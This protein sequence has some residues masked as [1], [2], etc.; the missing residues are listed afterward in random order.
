MSLR[1]R[2]TKAKKRVIDKQFER[3]MIEAD[4]R[5]KKRQAEKITILL[6]EAEA[7]HKS[8]KGIV[9][10][11]I[12]SE[13]PHAEKIARRNAQDWKKIIGW[14]KKELKQLRGK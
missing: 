8:W 10:T 4:N 1:P 11:F 2:K 13:N 6:K 14:R 9:E 12:L 5:R 7:E 3:R